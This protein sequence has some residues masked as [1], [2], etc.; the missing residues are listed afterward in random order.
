[1]GYNGRGCSRVLVAFMRFWYSGI[2]N[3]MSLI[4]KFVEQI[5]LVLSL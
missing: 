2:Q 3:L 1:M 5:V 4:V